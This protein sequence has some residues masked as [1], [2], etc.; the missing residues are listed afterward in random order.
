MRTRW[1]LHFLFC[2]EF[3]LVVFRLPIWIVQWLSFNSFNITWRAI[4]ANQEKGSVRINIVLR[5]VWINMFPKENTD[6]CTPYI[7]CYN[8]N[9]NMHFNNNKM[10]LA[11]H[12]MPDAEIRTDMGTRPLTHQRLPLSTSNTVILNK[13]Q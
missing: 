8:T 10:I 12:N 9:C 6:K 2:I 4:V 11:G 3:L 7:D 1:M 13:T 5:S